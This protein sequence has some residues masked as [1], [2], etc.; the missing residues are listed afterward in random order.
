MVKVS[1]K[2]YR[3][4][5]SSFTTSS[6]GENT[7]GRLSSHPHSHSQIP[8]AKHLTVETEWKDYA[9]DGRDW[10]ELRKNYLGPHGFG[11]FA[12]TSWCH[13]L[14]AKPCQTWTRIIFPCRVH[15]T[16]IPHGDSN[17]RRVGPSQQ[18]VYTIGTWHREGSGLCR[19][20]KRQPQ[21]CNHEA[22]RRCKPS[23]P[24]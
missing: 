1:H 14:S 24:C 22:A 2:S 9:F 16:L 20:T 6:H 19:S 5:A 10:M 21:A 12:N 3:N 17:W 8:V 11:S 13:T 15:P 4:N 18:T 7:R 23:Q